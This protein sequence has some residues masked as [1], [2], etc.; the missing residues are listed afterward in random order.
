MSR[1]SFNFVAELEWL[2]VDA[3]YKGSFRWWWKI[4]AIFRF[5]FNARQA[6]ATGESTISDF[7]DGVGDGDARQAGA[8]GESTISDFGDGVADGDAR[9]AALI[10]RIATDLGDGVGDGDAGQAA[11]VKERIVADGGDGVGDYQVRYL[12]AV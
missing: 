6:G 10:E 1:Y 8:T 9:Q 12:T 5:P 2:D 3:S 4:V 11:A 7:G